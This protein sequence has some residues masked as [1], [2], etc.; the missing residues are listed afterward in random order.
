MNSLKTGIILLNMGGP[1]SLEQVRPFLYNLFSD[2]DIIPLGPKLLQKPIAWMVAKK[3]A[4]KS[5]ATYQMIGGGSPLQKITRMQ[6][7][8]LEKSL[9]ND[10][11]F[12]A[13]IA[14]R[15]W[16][17]YGMETVEKMVD[18]GVK[19]IIALSLYP[20]YSK[21]TTGSSLKHLRTAIAKVAQ[22]LPVQEVPFW[23]CQTSY[24]KAIAENINAARREFGSNC[25]LVYSAHSLPVSFI[26]DGDPYL[27]HTKQTIKAI[28]SL[29]QVKGR[30]CFQSRSGPV[31]WLAPSTPDT[32]KEMADEGCKDIIMV[33]ISFVSDH[34]ETLY[35][36]DIEYKELAESLGMRLNSCAS[37]NTQ[38]LFIEGLRELVL[39]ATAKF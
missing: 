31:E 16:P 25:H 38:P 36:I 15:Y 39:E 23:P 3:R 29:T 27:E 5:M 24:V 30:L 14:M 19:R 33:P 10:G 20:H 37:L 17:P 8:A 34:V 21:A 35:E 28:E 2:R 18:R 1:S 11:D 32:L 4:P 9:Q 6:A 13:D 7:A 12:I 26:K 22:D